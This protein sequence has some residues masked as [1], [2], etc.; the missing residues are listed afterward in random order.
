[1]DRID[2]DDSYYLDANPQTR[3]GIRV[4][5]RIS[6]GLKVYASAAYQKRRIDDK[7][8]T[9]LTGGVRKS[10]LFG[11]DIAGRYTYIDNFTSK[12]NEFNIDLSRTFLDKFDVSLYA[13]HEEEEL[14]IEGGF[15]SGLLT[16]GASFYWQINR[17]Y[18]FLVFVERY[19]EDDY[20]NTSMFTQ[21]GYRF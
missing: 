17:N 20:Y 2:L 8:A 1:L 11:F 18:H 14:E 10:D 13:S 19:D 7:E 5:Y 9:R 16:Y 6:K 15:T 4:D 3:T 12:D 21:V